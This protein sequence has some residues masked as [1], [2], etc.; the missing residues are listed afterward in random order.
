MPDRQAPADTNETGT[1]EGRGCVETAGGWTTTGGGLCAGGTTGGSTVRLRAEISSGLSYVK[2]SA[3]G[4]KKDK[5]SIL[6]RGV[7][8]SRQSCEASEDTA[9]SDV[10]WMRSLMM[11]VSGGIPTSAEG[12]TIFGW[13]SFTSFAGG[14]RECTNGCNDMDEARRGG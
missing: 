13:K 1:G 7:A 14:G 2:P 11:S 10:S 12:T 9:E 4:W 3:F 8:F 6:R 5:K